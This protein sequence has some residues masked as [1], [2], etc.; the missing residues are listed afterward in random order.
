MSQ[1]KELC[2]ESGKA[3]EPCLLILWYFED[4]LKNK[5]AEFVDILEVISFSNFV[6]VVSFITKT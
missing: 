4:L 3:G 2:K 6:F 1:I 5:C